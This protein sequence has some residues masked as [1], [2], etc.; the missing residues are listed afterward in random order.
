M[1][2]ALILIGIGIF[3]YCIHM[4]LNAAGLEL[5]FY[6]TYLLWFVVMGIFF[7]VLPG[8]LPNIIQ[9]DELADA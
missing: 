4:M 5:S 6:I 3:A 2:G 1:N 9:P 8:E 7:I